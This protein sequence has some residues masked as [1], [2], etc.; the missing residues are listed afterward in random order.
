MVISWSQYLSSSPEIPSQVLSQFLWYNNYIKIE[1]TVIHF[2]KFSN[3]MSS[4]RSY[5]KMEG[6]YHRS[7]SNINTI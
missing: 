5:L 2:E 4:Y 1:D 6:L 3:K 7:I